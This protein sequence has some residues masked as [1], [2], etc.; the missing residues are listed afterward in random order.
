MGEVRVENMKELTIN[1]D[2]DL[3]RELKRTALHNQSGV[4]AVVLTI[5]AN[6]YTSRKR[7]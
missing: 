5:L 1:I 6:Y 3:F 4:E 7:D 2:N